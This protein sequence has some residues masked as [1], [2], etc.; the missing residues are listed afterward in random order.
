MKLSPAE[1][2]SLIQLLTRIY[3]DIVAVETEFKLMT[4]EGDFRPRI[5]YFHDAV[6][7]FSS[8]DPAHMQPGGRLSVELLAYDVSCLRFL[9]S[10]PLAPFKPHSA[11]NVE[12]LS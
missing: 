8:Q 2:D 6:R 3:L 12:H 9:A 11:H 1:Q 7:A 5:E 10:M 4:G